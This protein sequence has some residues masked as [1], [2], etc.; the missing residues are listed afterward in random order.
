ML[1]KVDHTRKTNITQYKC[2]RCGVD[3]YC[4]D[5]SGKQNSFRYRVSAI[6]Q[7]TPGLTKH[8]ISFDLCQACMKKMI[9]FIR[10]PKKELTDN[11]NT[12]E[13]KVKKI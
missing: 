7:Y 9:I 1:I 2:D 4:G 3:I 5:T 8:A 13:S 6:K 11:G 10:K 12:E